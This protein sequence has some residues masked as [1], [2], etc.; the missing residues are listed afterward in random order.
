MQT[1]SLVNLIVFF[2]HLLASKFDLLPSFL[3]IYFSALYMPS[4]FRSI[5]MDL[6]D[7]IPSLKGL[8]CLHLPSKYCEEKNW[9]L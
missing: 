8:T 4:M 7:K 2:G 6:G 5:A 9:M 1:S 3:P